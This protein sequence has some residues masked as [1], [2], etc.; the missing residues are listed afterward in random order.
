MMKDKYEIVGVLRGTTILKQN[1]RTLEKAEAVSE[2]FK[3]VMKKKPREEDA[4]I[5]IRELGNFQYGDFESV[6]NLYPDQ[7]WGYT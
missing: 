5:E 4:F 3:A 7:I 1:A 6:E 2:E